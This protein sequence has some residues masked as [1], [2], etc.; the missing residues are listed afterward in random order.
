MP[1]KRTLILLILL[2]L[3]LLFIWGHS[4]VPR[5]ESAEESAAVSSVLQYFLD[6]LH[7]P[8][9][10]TDRFV[11]KLAHLAEHA[12]AGFLLGLIVFPLAAGKKTRKALLYAAPFA[13]GFLVGLTDET[14]QL[15]S[16]RGALFG[17][18]LTDFAGASAGALLSLFILYLKGKRKAYGKNNEQEKN[19]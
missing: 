4:L 15:F 9:T 18:V 2:I 7:I 19:I 1:A 16:G 3:V 13:A 17:D 12:A 10:L 14:I 6:M 8:L 11:R 5:P